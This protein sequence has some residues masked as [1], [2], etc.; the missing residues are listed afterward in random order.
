MLQVYLLPT[1][2]YKLKIRIMKSVEEYFYLYYDLKDE[3]IRLSK[4]G[5][6]IRKA[7]ITKIYCV[8]KSENG[9]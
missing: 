1:N 8:P 4:E 3:M 6:D 5:N 2:T 9:V 7:F